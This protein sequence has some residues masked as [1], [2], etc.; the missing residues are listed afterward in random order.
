MNNSEKL[1]NYTPNQDLIR[2]LSAWASILDSQHQTILLSFII[3]TLHIPHH[4]PFLPWPLCPP[5]DQIR[6]NPGALQGSLVV[7]ARFNEPVLRLLT[8]KFE[9]GF[10]LAKGER[11]W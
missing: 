5:S 6:N 9:N 3:Q 1:L 2:D 8:V 4:A 11:C 7:S 10:I